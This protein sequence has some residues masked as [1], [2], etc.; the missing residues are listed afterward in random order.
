MKKNCNLVLGLCF[1]LFYLFSNCVHAQDYGAAIGLRAFTY[2]GI[3]VSGKKIFGENKAIELNAIFRGYSFYNY[4]EVGALY[5]K[6]NEISG[7]DGLNWLVGGGANVAFYNYEFSGSDLDF[8]I[9]GIVGLE[10][11]FP[12]APVT[13]GL[14]YMPLFWLGDGFFFSS[15]RGG[16]SA[17]YTF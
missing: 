12:N 10:Y 16:F 3:G 9:S 8:G 7:V 2:G 1:A 5:E 17:R 13:I 4:L 11:K 15:N 6:Y 14:D